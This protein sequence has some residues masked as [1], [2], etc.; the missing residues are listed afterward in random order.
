M[1]EYSMPNSLKNQSGISEV[2]T[3]PTE[4]TGLRRTQAPKMSG[5]WP[6]TMG[7]RQNHSDKSTGIS[8]LTMRTDESAMTPTYVKQ[9]ARVARRLALPD[10]LAEKCKGIL[11]VKRAAVARSPKPSEP[12]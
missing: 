6:T 1:T 8:A 10:Q 11:D 2:D 4:M 9:P 12:V 3:S 5:H 7:M